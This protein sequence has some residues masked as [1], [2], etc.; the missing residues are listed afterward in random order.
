MFRKHNKED[1]QKNNNNN[2]NCKPKNDFVI[3]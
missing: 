3:P 1:F 2:N